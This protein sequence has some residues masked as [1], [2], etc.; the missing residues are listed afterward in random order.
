MS[1]KGKKKW[2]TGVVAAL[3]G[4]FA[5]GA[6]VGLVQG[7]TK[8]LKAR[9][10]EVGMIDTDGENAKQDKDAPLAF[11]TKDFIDYNELNITFDKEA[12]GYTAKVFFYDEDEEVVATLNVG[13]GCTVEE[14]EWKD[15]EDYTTDGGST[16]PDTIES[17]RVMVMLP[18]DEDEDGEIS[19]LE[20]WKY[21]K[22]VSI[23]Y[24]KAEK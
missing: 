17:V 3:V 1:K 10:Y 2:I 24:E 20:L 16:L 4:V 21:H 5:V 23:T 14:F 15:R 22:N 13:E 8:E 6:V 19:R 11:R 12:E 18:E 9:H 7:D